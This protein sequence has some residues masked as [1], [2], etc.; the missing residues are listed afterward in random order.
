MASLDAVSLPASGGRLHRPMS[1][2]VG[3]SAGFLAAVVVVALLADW[4][5]PIHYTTQNL[6][7]RLKPPLW[8]LQAASTFPS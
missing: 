8:S 1:P 7:A 6:A 2:V 5:A 4:L 3:L